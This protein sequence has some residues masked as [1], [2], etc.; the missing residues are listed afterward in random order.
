MALTMRPFSA[1]SY[2]LSKVWFKCSSISMRQ[3]DISNINT[4]IKSWLYQDLLQKP[5]ELTLYRNC[6]DGGLGLLNVKYRALA[7]LI[8]TFMETASHPAFRHSLYHEILFRYYVLEEVSLSRPDFT[9]YYDANFFEMIKYYH[10]NS[11]LNI[12]VLSLRQWYRLLL[13]VKVLMS[14]ANES[15][16]AYLLPVRCESLQ[17]DSN[18]NYAW[19][20]MRTSGLSSNC[21]SFLFKLV[22]LLLPTQDRVHRL[23][24]TRNNTEGLCLL[25]RSE[26]EDLLHS[27]FFCSASA[28]AGLV[29]LGWAQELVPCLTQEHSLRLDVVD[30]ILTTDEELALV[31]I[32]GHGLGYIWER[33]IRKKKVQLYEIRAEMEATVSLLRK[34]RHRKA[35]DIIFNIISC[36]K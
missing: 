12:S 3:S 18:W 21:S 7:L 10:N 27:F 15:G 4:A 13:E 16:P 5:G 19:Q 36:E 22:H 6:K 30:D 29:T 34:S 25:C 31:T 20:L 17:P 28:E 23:G 32:I 14:P 1:N 11:P 24:L 26:R 8:R 33:R 35:G 9:P 2:A